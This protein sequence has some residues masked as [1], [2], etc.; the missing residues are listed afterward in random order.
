[1]LEDFVGNKGGGDKKEMRV[2]WG[3]EKLALQG[4][5]LRFLVGGGEERRWGRRKG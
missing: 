1:V 2:T 4:D 3:V 5:F